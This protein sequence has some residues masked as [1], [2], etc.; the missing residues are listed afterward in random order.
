MRETTVLRASAA[1]TDPSSTSQI[2][3]LHVLDVHIYI[4]SYYINFPSFLMSAS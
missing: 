2:L 4:Y 1:E 3:V